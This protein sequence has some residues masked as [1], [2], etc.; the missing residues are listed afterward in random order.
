MVVVMAILVA[1]AAWLLPRYL[2]NAGQASPGRTMI[3]APTQR[4][5]GVDCSNNLRQI[6]YALTM[7]QQTNE[8]YPSSLGELTSSGITRD[9]LVCPVSK[10]PYLYDPNTGRVGC[11]Y[12]PHRAF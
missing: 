8:R 3:Q 1:L 7:A 4:A 2:G 11:S 9:M 5:E 12:Q 6:R 10:Q